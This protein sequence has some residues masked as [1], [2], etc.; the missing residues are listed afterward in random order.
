MTTPLRIGIICL[1]IMTLFACGEHIPIPQIAAI[2]TAVPA[3]TPIKDSAPTRTVDASQIPNA[4][5]KHE[6]RSKN[7]NPP[8]YE[9]YGKRYYVSDSNVNYKERGIASWYGTKFQN[10]RTSSGAPYDMFAMTA[11]HKTLPLPTYVKVKNLQ[12]GREIIVKVN[13]RGPFHE[14]RIIDLSYVAAKKLG[15]LHNGTAMV[16]VTSL[17]PKAPAT[18][19]QLTETSP[20]PLLYMQIGSFS[21]AD[22]AKRLSAKI[23][24]ALHAP[25]RIQVAL[26]ANNQTRYQVQIGPLKDAQQF[27]QIAQRLQNWG[28]KKPLAVVA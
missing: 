7:G 4:T 14:N 21:Q 5:P 12:N 18:Q 26:N 19:T 10:K 11:A 27:D 8:Y 15:M 13:D 20:R 24:T 16:E 23:K 9:V 25:V 28:I 2:P 22:N 3:A 17:T 1:L 6:P